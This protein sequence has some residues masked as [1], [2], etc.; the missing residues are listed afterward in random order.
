MALKTSVLSYDYWY[1]TKFLAKTIIGASNY[2][3]SNFSN[4]T[5]E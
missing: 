3:L 5:E 4:Q 1:A 2:R